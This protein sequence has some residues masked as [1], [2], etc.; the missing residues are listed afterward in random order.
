MAARVVEDEEGSMGAASSEAQDQNRVVVV[1]GVVVHPENLEVLLRG[2]AAG[3]FPCAPIDP[4]AEPVDWALRAAQLVPHT[5]L[6]GVWVDVL[7]AMLASSE[8]AEVELARALQEQCASVS[9]EA[10]CGAVDGHIAA[11]RWAQAERALGAALILHPR[12]LL[13]YSPRVRA[14]LS[15]SQTTPG[16]LRYALMV[17]GGYDAGWLAAHTDL[18]MGSNP[19]ESSLRMGWACLT[20]NLFLLHF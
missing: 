19:A 15:R 7:V 1:E 8:S 4:G 10:I 14:W 9:F 13:E 11:A 2:V 18:W 16:V 20:Q 17:M 5:A 3:R 6:H 12:G